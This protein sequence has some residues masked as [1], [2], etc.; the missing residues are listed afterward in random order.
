MEQP[1][2]DLPESLQQQLKSCRTLPSIP[3]VAVRILELSREE[4]ASVNE[5]A[6]VIGRDPALVAKLLRVSNSAF[7]G[8]RHEV[9]TVNRAVSVLGINTALSLAL[10]FSLAKNLGRREGKS[11]DPIAYW[12][13]S[14]ISAA[15]GRALAQSMQGGV[16]EELF[17]AG[18]LQD[19]GMLVLNEAVPNA[20]DPLIAAAKGSHRL[21]VEL[22]QEKFGT[23][24]AA[25]GAWLLEIWNLPPK[26]RTA[27][28]ASHDALMLPDSELAGFCRATSV[29]A[30]IAE[31][32]VDPANATSIAWS[33]ASGLLKMSPEG[34]KG[35]LREVAAAIPE[36]T[37]ELEINI[38]SEEMINQLLEQAHEALVSL[39]M[40]AQQQVQQ[41]R[42]LSRRDRLT[43]VYNRGFLEEELPKQFEAA[44]QSGKPLSVLFIDIDFFKK[45]NDTHGHE[46]GDTVLVSTAGTI[47]TAART[48]DVIAR[49]GGEEFI[50]LMPNTNA[51]EA[52]TVGEQI[53]SSVASQTIGDAPALQ[54]TVS[55]GG[56][57]HSRQ[58]KLDDAK[59]LLGEADRCLYMAKAGGRN[60]MIMMH[61][62]VCSNC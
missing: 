18:L 4:D 26:Y 38:G 25:V 19:V 16:R 61:G 50:C 8:V 41:I 48:S 46:T 49:Y 60:K 9:T 23:D 37:G 45:V 59:H 22:E 10:S 7:Y 13:R 47:R 21:L 20:Y 62:P 3:A 34:F 36:V 24:H 6:Q 11:F 15:A 30:D 35:L 28:R 58:R 56:A 52:A 43:A 14:A 54:V 57:T 39:T 17:L 53:R 51:D 55:I 31:I 1:K 40:Q 32:W 29:A 27:V 42:D 33:S 12:R 2:S 44:S 5:I